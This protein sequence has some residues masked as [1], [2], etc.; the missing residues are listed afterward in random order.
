MVENLPPAGALGK[1]MMY[2]FPPSEAV[3]R[4]LRVPWTPQDLMLLALIVPSAA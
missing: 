1:R 3:A 4:G 2:L